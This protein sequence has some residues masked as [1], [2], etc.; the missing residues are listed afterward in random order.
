MAKRTGIDEHLE[1]GDPP[2]VDDLRQLEADGFQT[3][4]DLRADDS[5]TDV[6]RIVTSHEEEKETE[7]A[8]QEE[9]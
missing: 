4:I 6:A 7:S 2:S 9:Q 8:A 3:V 5:V 1:I